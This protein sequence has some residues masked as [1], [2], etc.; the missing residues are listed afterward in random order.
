MCHAYIGV[1]AEALGAVACGASLDADPGEGL[2]VDDDLGVGLVVLEED[3]VAGL[4][5]LDQRVLENEGLGL[6]THDDVLYAA[7]LT[8]QEACLG[9]L[10]LTLE[11]AADASA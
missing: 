9:A 5:L 8:H 3:V 7:Y 6:A 2:V 11:V 4:V 1:G 10:H